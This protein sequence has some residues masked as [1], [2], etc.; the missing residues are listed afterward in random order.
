MRSMQARR[1]ACLLRQ[2]VVGLSMQQGGGQLPVP[3]GPVLCLL[4]G[5]KMVSLSLSRS[6]SLSL[7]LS[8]SLSL[9][10]SLAFSLFLD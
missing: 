7:A 1:R 4:L 10:L 9:S 5:P 8:L 3:I 2:V 6:L